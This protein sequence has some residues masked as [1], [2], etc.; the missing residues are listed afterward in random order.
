MLSP[1]QAQFVQGVFIESYDPTIEDSYRKQIDVDG[2][3]VM[4][5]IMDTAGTEQFTS[6]R[7]FYMRDAHGFLLVF[8]ITSMSSLEELR[9]LREQIVQIKGGD[10]HVPIVLVGNKSDLEEDR[11]VSRSQA[12]KVSQAWGNVPYYETSA[13]RRQNV[14]EVFVD[15]CRQIIRK[16]LSRARRDRGPDRPGYGAHSD[17]RSSGRRKRRRQRTYDDYDDDRRGGR[18]RCVIL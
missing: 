10:P 8:S 18:S 4:L 7:E 6:M 3:Q 1:I 9:E 15:V 16:D 12:F 17:P 2:R 14:S 11:K 13:R 5:E